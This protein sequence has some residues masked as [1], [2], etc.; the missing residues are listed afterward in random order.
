MRFWSSRQNIGQYNEHITAGCSYQH[1]SFPTVLRVHIV[2]NSKEYF[3]KMDKIF[4]IK[5]WKFK[6]ADIV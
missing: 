1:T 4:K 5:K 6:M 2:Q 3:E